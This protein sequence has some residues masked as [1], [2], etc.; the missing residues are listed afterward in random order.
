MPALLGKHHARLRWYLYFIGGFIQ[1]ADADAVG[2]D[3]SIGNPDQ[4]S[5][6]IGTEVLRKF[7]TMLLEEGHETIIIDPDEANGRAVRAYEKAGFVAYDRYIDDDS[8]TLLMKLDLKRF[9]E[10]LG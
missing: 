4:L 5:R 2:V 8:V 7:L 3:L 9:R 10:T 1:R 6:G